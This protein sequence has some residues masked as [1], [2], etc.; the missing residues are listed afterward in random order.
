MADLI[1]ING[2]E[3][4]KKEV[5]ESSLPVLVDFWAVWCGP[6]QMM[7]PVLEDIAK[8]H[9]D[10]IKIVKLDTDQGVNQQIAMDYNIQSIP[11]M[12]VF[13]DGKLVKELIGY[14]PKDVLLGEL[15]EFLE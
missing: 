11:N 15:K 2:T 13:K 8:D 5:L 7:A 9:G 3:N 4:F 14:R 1:N 6:C 12:K 10:K